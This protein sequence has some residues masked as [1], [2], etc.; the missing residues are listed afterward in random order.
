MFNK[1]LIANRGE[2]ACR[3]IRTLKKLNIT[4]VAVYSDA[5]RH[6]QHVKLADEAYYLGPAPA[7]ES[8]LCIDKIIAIA[9]K[10]HVEAIHPG[11]GFLAENANFARAC[12]HAGIIFIGPPVPAI[13]SMGSK[14]GAKALMMK[15]DVPTLPGYHNKDQNPEILFAAAK[16]IGFPVLIKASFGGGGRGMR[17]VHEE[18]SFSEALA[19]AKREALNSF[20]NDEVILEKYLAMPRHVEVQIFADQAQNYV[21]LFERDCSIQRRH[22]KVIEEAPAPRVD[23]ELRARLGEAAVKAAQAIGYVGAGTVEFLLSDDGQFY[24]MEMNTRLQVEH[25]I[26]EMITGEDLV[27]WQLR[28]AQGAPLPKRQDQLKIHGAAIEV[29]LCAEDPYNDF[30]PSTGK[31]LIYDYPKNM[32]HVRMDTGFIAGDEVSI[33]YDS[34]LGKLIAW[35][36][37]REAARRTL[38]SALDQTEVLGIKTNRALLSKILQQDDFIQA[39]L[40]T[41]FIAKHEKTLLTV[42]E[43][44]PETV[45]SAAAAHYLYHLKKAHKNAQDPWQSLIGWHSSVEVIF[46]YLDQQHK[47]K[48]GKSNPTEHIRLWHHGKQWI[49]HSQYE[50]YTFYEASRFGNQNTQSH[51]DNQLTAPMPGRIIAQPVNIGDSVKRGQTLLIMEAMKMEHTIRAPFDGMI[52]ALHAKVG[53]TV[54]ENTQLVELN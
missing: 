17:I 7:A 23:E 28:I 15:H 24:F 9:K 42:P 20:G 36:K 25:P 32:P 44:I 50:S 29:R 31:I 54:A 26:T 48:A 21:Y 14:A 39:H 49:A 30:L 16:A 27:E 33:Y 6:A 43:A 46:Q 41:H 11:Y 52:K 18:A 38:L 2:I 10:A 22:Q 37:N 53:D 40:S 4:A 8:Y 5:D 34:L 35:G 12:E 13:E 45:L 51:D 19:T 1:V 47:I 3:I